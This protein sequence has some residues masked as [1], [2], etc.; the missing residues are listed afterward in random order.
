MKISI[1][2][3]A[4]ETEEYKLPSDTQEVYELLAG[5]LDFAEESKLKELRKVCLQCHPGDTIN[6]WESTVTFR[7]SLRFCSFNI[8]P[9]DATE[10]IHHNLIAYFSFYLMLKKASFEGITNENAEL[11]LKEYESTLSFPP[12]FFSYQN[13]RHIIECFLPDG[14]V[15]LFLQQESHVSKNSPLAYIHSLLHGKKKVN[16]VE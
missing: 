4:A 3:T 12:G 16:M 6:I 13:I 5:F 8:V 1:K 2:T 11:V 14:E 9:F 15:N 7:S 10:E